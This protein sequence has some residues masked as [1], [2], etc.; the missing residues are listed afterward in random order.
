L[1]RTPLVSIIV[2]NY[3]GIKYINNCLESVLLSEYENFELIIV[4]NNSTDKS[5]EFVEDT[6]KDARL[7]VIRNDTNMGFAAG[8]NIGVQNAKGK[9][10]ALLNIDTIVDRMWLTEIILLLESDVTIGVAQ[11]K[12]LSLDD[13]SIFD[14]AGDY[15]DYFGLPICRGGSWFERDTGQ[16]DTIQEIFSARGAALVTRKEIISAIGLFDNDYFLD[17]EDLDFCWRVKLYGKRVVFVP[18]SIVYHKGAGI[19]SQNSLALKNIHPTKN[20]IMTL[21]KNYNTFHMIKYAILPHLFAFFTGFFVLE[22][23]LMKR[24]N[25]LANI[26]FRVQA[27]LWILRNIRRLHTKRKEV[28]HNIRKV[29]DS[30]IMKCMIKTSVW[31]VAIWIINIQKEGKDKAKRSYFVNGLSH[32]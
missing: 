19:S 18:S 11:P 9:Y 16:Y 4:D 22:V 21:I 31:R 1:T 28:Q 12:L 15:L 3:N 27:Y 24:E 26:K 17:F 8:N 23:F 6:F 5:V 20:S 10:V 25:K 32:S 14:S 13:R 30:E 2:L 7:N 29:S